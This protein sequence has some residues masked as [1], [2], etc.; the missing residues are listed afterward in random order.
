[1]QQ[2]LKHYRIPPSTTESRNVPSNKFG[3]VDEND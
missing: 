3:E 1:M 2:A